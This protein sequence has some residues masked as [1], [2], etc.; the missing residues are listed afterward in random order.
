MLLF[1]V[2]LW[3]VNVRL[4]RALRGQAASNLDA[5]AGVFENFQELRGRDLL[6]R[7]RNI[8]SDP[9][10][11]AVSQVQDAKTLVALYRWMQ[12]SVHLLEPA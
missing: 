8:Q 11:K 10:F 2:S 9:R 7:A 6:L 4:T 5:V 12:L 3:V 1:G